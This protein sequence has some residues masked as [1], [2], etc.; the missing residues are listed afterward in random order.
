MQLLTLMAPL[1]LASSI[2]ARFLFAPEGFQHPNEALQI[3]SQI[4]TD[5]GEILKISPNP[6]GCG[7]L[8]YVFPVVGEDSVIKISSLNVTN[9]IKARS[10]IGWYATSEEAAILDRLE[11]L[12]GVY[13][14]K[15]HTILKMKKVKG[16]TL[17]HHIESGLI[18]S[19]DDLQLF[20]AAVFKSVNALHRKGIVHND[21]H[22]GNILYEVTVDANDPLK[23]IV[24]VKANLVD[25]GRSEILK[26]PPS[27]W[28]PIRARDF[29]Y[30]NLWFTEVMKFDFEF[31]WDKPIPNP[32][33]KAPKWTQQKKWA[34][35]DACYVSRKVKEFM[36]RFPKPLGIEGTSL[37]LDVPYS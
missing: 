4:K 11:M 28:K 22:V 24:E 26:V 5:Q 27:R 37:E 16:E 34:A 8:S 32:A 12:E 25:F 7:G 29:D 9:E 14:L 10:S 3:S 30:L 6:L 13:S 2:Q 31:D 35:E 1:I 15:Q 17:Q 36:K 23:K 21:L 33:R 20:G 19:Y 18:Q